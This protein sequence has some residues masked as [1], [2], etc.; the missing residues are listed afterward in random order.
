MAEKIHAGVCFSSQFLT[1][2]VLLY[3]PAACIPCPPLPPQSQ[4]SSATVNKAEMVGIRKGFGPPLRAQGPARVPNPSSWHHSSAGTWWPGRRGAPCLCMMWV[5]VQEGDADAGAEVLHK[6]RIELGRH[7]IV[8]GVSEAALKPA[9]DT[10]ASAPDG[11]AGSLDSSRSYSSFTLG[12]SHSRASVSSSPRGTSD[13]MLS[14]ATTR[15][16]VALDDA[17]P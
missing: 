10:W 11:P 12:W 3:L 17:C 13:A 9:R 4:P 16:T 7:G 15:Y 1:G 2:F 5:R 6:A 8:W 14:D